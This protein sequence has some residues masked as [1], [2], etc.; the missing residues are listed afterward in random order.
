MYTPV[1]AKTN[2]WTISKKLIRVVTKGEKESFET[3]EHNTD[4]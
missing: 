4:F 1:F 3:C 2:T